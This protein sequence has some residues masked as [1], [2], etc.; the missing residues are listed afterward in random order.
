MSSRT[1]NAR[2]SPPLVLLADDNEDARDMYSA[3]L[4]YAGF[5]VATAIDG[6]HAIEIARRERPSVIL[7]DATMPVLDGWAAIEHLKADAQ[8]RDVPVLMLTAHVFP[9]HE[10]RARRLGAGFLRKPCLPDDLV[11]AVRQVLSVK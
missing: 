7:M 4:A 5:R 10:E 8:L 9:E 3:Y 2:E 1:S 11:E 6:A